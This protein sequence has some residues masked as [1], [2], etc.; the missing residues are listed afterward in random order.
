MENVLYMAIDIWPCTSNFKC[1]GNT[2]ISSES[3]QRTYISSSM[4]LTLTQPKLNAAQ[5]ILLIAIKI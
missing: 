3:C 1:I 2:K 5:L 4:A